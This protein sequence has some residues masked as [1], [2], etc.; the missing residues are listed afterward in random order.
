MSART[1]RAFSTTT[2]VD[3]SERVPSAREAMVT[4]FAIAACDAEPSRAGEIAVIPESGGPQELGRGPGEDARVPRMRFF[5]QR[6]ASLVETPPLGSPGISRQQLLVTPNEDGTIRVQRIGKCALAVND[7]RTDDAIVAAG[8]VVALKRDLVLLCARRPALIPNMRLFP[9]SGWGAFGEVDAF[10]MLGES[11]SAWWLRERVAFAAKADTHVLVLGESGTGKELA[12]RAIHQLSSRAGRPFIARNAATLPSGL[13]DAEL[14]GNAKNYPNP[15]MPERAGLIGEADGGTLFLDE[16][17]ELPSELQAHLLRVLDADGEYQRLGESV[18][19]RSRFRL[20]AA[21]NRT[22][23]A[24]KHD[25]AAR[26]TARVEIPSLSQRRED[27]PLLARHLLLRAAKRSPEVAGH[28]ISQTDEGF[29][30]PAFTTALLGQLLRASYP[31]NVRDLEALLWRGMSVSSGDVIECPPDLLEAAQ[32]HDEPAEQRVPRPEPEA[33]E[34]RAALER[35]VG[36]VA[37]AARALGLSSR[38]AL[39]RLM[40]KHG[41]EPDSPSDP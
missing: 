3:T 33:A 26:L 36:R 37:D 38:Y 13:I 31:A 4:V 19:R 8:D 12:A 25:F 41:I 7:R 40:K 17:G 28:F 9:R 34:I 32:A 27:I 18:T 16:I 23:S 22:A 6:P 21:T 30:Y 39:Y 14:F 24:L 1:P 11:P 35:H 20:V 5:R 2:A 29:E 10:G 15:G